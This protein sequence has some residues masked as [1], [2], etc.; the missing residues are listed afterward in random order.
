[1]AEGFDA[2][3]AERPGDQKNGRIAV[4]LALACVA[5]VLIHIFSPDERFKTWS[6]QTTHL[7]LDSLNQIVLLKD[8]LVAPIVYSNVSGL[9]QLHVPYAKEM[10]VSVLL[11]SIL[12]AKHSLSQDRLRMEYLQKKK[13]NW[14]TYDSIFYLERKVR[15]RA[16]GP[17]NLLA[18]MGALPNSIVLAQAAVESGWGRSRF[19]LEGN[20]VFGIWSYN[21]GEPRIMAGQTR[22]ST[23]IYV[24]AYDNITQ[25][26]E[27]YFE[28]LG[29]ARAYHHL[30][31]ARLETNDP[32]I[33]LP[34]LKYYSERRT[35][36]TNQL[37]T[38]IM[39]NDFTRYDNFRIDPRYLVAE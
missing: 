38:I 25:S 28:T 32:F 39:Q 36:Y 15:Y 26:I 14:D 2:T 34:H 10:F 21:P 17:D 9:E 7:R 11:P 18:R 12:V 27:D 1:M 31:K 13:K 23:A 22:D 33:L 24:R 5:V 37:K 29:S 8:S 4:I 6:V 3:A 20:N 35:H 30:R 19:F 16:S